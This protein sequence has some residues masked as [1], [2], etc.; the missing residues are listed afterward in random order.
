[1]ILVIDNY[2]SFTYNIVQLLGQILLPAGEKVFV[3]RNDQITLAEIE[4][5]GPRGILLS[6]G[7]GRPEGAG[8][9]VEVVRTFGRM[10]PMLGVCLGHQAIGL[11]FGGSVVQAPTI[12]HGLTSLVRHFN[13][14]VFDNIS[15]PFVAT[16][17]HSLVLSPENFPTELEMTAMADDGV[18]MGIRH[19]HFPI[20]GVQFHPESILTEHGES[21]LRNWL[22]AA[23]IQVQQSP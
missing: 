2:D 4:E 7:P 21:I 6:P 17:Y 20:V 18:I 10:I 5:I 19:K 22:R 1:M 3:R 12:M 13:T 15:N 23:G 14:S 16:R 8:I 9:T 11:A